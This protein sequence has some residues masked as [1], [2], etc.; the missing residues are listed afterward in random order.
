MTNKCT[1]TLI[2]HSKIKIYIFW[3]WDT[4]TEYSQVRVLQPEASPLFDWCGFCSIL[5]SVQQAITLVSFNLLLQP[6]CTNIIPFVK[7][8]IGFENGFP[9]GGIE[10]KIDYFLPSFLGQKQEF[11]FH[12]DMVKIVWIASI[13]CVSGRI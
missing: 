8:I 9:Y 5:N 4:T 13:L 3:V 6:H 10:R 11:R 12:F 7:F 1:W 2:L